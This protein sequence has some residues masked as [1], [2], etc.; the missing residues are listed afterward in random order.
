MNQHLFFP[1]LIASSTLPH[2]NQFTSSQSQ[3]RNQPPFPCSHPHGFARRRLP[4]DPGELPRGNNAP[5]CSPGRKRANPGRRKRAKKSVARKGLLRVGHMVSRDRDVCRR[6]RLGCRGDFP[7]LVYRM[8]R[9][10]SHLER[11]DCM[12]N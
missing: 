5:W 2:E 4:I 7:F 8:R 9:R 1:L 11:E 6:L 12:G 10:V 3:H